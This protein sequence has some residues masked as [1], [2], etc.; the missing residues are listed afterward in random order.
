MK[1][2]VLLL[3]GAQGSGKSTFASALMQNSAVP[4]HRV[5]QARFIR[6]R[7]KQ[8]IAGCQTLCVQDTIYNTA[9]LP[10][11]LQPLY[12]GIGCVPL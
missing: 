6:A 5:N 10:E 8:C 3:C 12:D 7:V 9:L 11:R 2:L 4:W 1:P